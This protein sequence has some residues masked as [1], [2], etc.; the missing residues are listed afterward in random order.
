MVF[1]L[2]G[3]I[4]YLSQCL[5]QGKLFILFPKQLNA[6]YNCL[7]VF[8]IWGSKK[9]IAHKGL[10]NRPILQKKTDGLP[11]HGDI[12]EINIINTVDTVVL[13]Q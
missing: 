2:S 13:R 7:L 10:R 11:L 4:F 8:N 6:H 3:S 1:I 5:L 12:A 9:T